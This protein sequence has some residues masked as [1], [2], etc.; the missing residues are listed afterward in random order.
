MLPSKK[1]GLSGRWH[2]LL[3]L[4]PAAVL[5]L[6]AVQIPAFAEWYA[7][8]PYRILS[9]WGN[10]L[11]SIV[12]FSIAE[13]LIVLLIPAILAYLTAASIK[14]K[15]TKQRRKTAL[16]YFVIQPLCAVSILFFL[17]TI[18]CGINYHRYTFAETSGLSIQPAGVEELE[19]LCEKLAADV[20]VL[21]S[22]VKTDDTGVMMLD[23]PG[24]HTVSQRAQSAMNAAGREYPLLSGNFGG[25]KPVFFSRVMSAC[26]TTGIFI[27][28][29]MEANVNVDISPYAI[30][31]TMCHELAHLN[32]FMREDEANFI[33]TLACAASEDPDFQYSGK[34]LSYRYVSNALYGEN[35]QAAQEI[36]STLNE[37]VRLDLQANSAYWKQFEGP[38]SETAT[39]VNNAYLKANRQEDGVKSYGRIVDL[40]LAEY[41]SGKMN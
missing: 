26:D 11:S 13:V 7:V 1:T 31:A 37:G 27:P 4:I 39:Q 17:F 22:Q 28:F 6:L 29:T 14:I 21:R 35:P 25:P 18:T 10:F 33:A 24:I 36:A 2:A 5:M 8:Y 16:T 20:N 34:M 41:R 9:Y 15:R 3:L 38:L 23:A 40:L 30:P 12:P 32:G 19:S